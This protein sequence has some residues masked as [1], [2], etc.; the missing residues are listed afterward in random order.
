MAYRALPASEK[1]CCPCIPTIAMH[2]CG[3]LEF[4]PKDGLLYM[5][6]GDTQGNLRDTGR[7][8]RSGSHAAAWQDHP[9][10]ARSGRARTPLGWPAGARRRGRSR[11]RTLGLRTPQSLAICV[12]S[13]DRRSVHPRRRAIPLGRTELSPCFGG[14]SSQLRMAAC[15][16]QRLRSELQGPEACLADLPTSEPRP[17]P[18]PGPR[19]DMCHHR[20]SGLPRPALSEMA[21]NIRLWRFMQWR[22][23]GPAQR[24][25][26]ARATNA[27]Q[28]RSGPEC[29]RNRLSWRDPAGR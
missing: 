25:K 21:R 24:R 1:S 9:P 27:C 15:G 8:R 23:L 19:A 4:G 18:G 29:D 3:H 20:R 22:D 17:L 12:R 7:H 28:H 16:R 5:C 14:R 10:Q 13:P 6:V 11:R 26:Q 2:Y